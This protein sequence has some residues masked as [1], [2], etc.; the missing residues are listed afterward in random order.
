MGRSD[1]PPLR[2]LSRVFVRGADPM[3]VIALPKEEVEKFRKVLRLEEGSQIAV[4]PNMAHSSDA[5][6]RPAWRIH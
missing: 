4:L 6:S 2:S 3:D 5:N 1:I